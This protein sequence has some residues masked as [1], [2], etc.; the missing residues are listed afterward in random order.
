MRYRTDEYS[1]Y[2]VDEERPTS[3]VWTAS[4]KC[5][6]ALEYL[7]QATE[8]NVLERTRILGSAIDDMSAQSRDAAMTRHRQ[9]QNMLK[10]QLSD[11]AA[12]WCTNMED[13]IR[14]QS[15]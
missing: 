8:S 15:Q 5:L 12:V 2:D 1:L 6:D 13:K 3:E 10:T 7:Y 11:I 9:E 14:S 4:E